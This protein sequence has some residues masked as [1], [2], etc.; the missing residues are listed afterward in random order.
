M[1][2]IISATEDEVSGLLNALTDKQASNVN[3]IKIF[4]GKFLD[5]DIVV[6]IQGVGI[7]KARNCTNTLIKKYKP[8]TIISAGFAGALNPK[9]QLGDVVI[10]DWVLSL[11]NSDKIYL[12]NNLPYIA[13]KF[14]NGGVLTEN[15]FINV[16]EKKLDLFVQSG[17]DVVDMETW[18]IADAARK[19]DTRVISVRSVSDLTNHHLP[20]MEQ[21]FNKESKFDTKKAFGYFKS[22]PDE[23]F[24]FLRFKYVN[25]RK[26]GVRLNSFLYL[27]IPVLNTIDN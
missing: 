25:L 5:I 23:I 16:K 12:D 17:A 15:S 8:N 19:L 11:K 21:I 14:L 24:N 1:I 9:L 27:L 3:S 20:R 2:A 4:A 6:A 10:P 7:R 22:N 13:F 26:A 18:A